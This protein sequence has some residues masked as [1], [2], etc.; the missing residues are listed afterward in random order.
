SLSEWHCILHYVHSFP[1]RRSSDLMDSTSILVGH[2]FAGTEILVQVHQSEGLWLD[3]WTGI[4]LAHYSN[5]ILAV[6]TDLRLPGLLTLTIDRKSTRLNSSH[7]KIS[8]A[9]FCLK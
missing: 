5:S 9:V 7:V 2:G 4:N 8:Y 1:A 6:W 3:E